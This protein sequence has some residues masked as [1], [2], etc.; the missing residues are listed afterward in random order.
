M[1]T[2][3]NNWIKREAQKRASQYLAEKQYERQQ[4]AEARRDFVIIAIGAL[5][6]ASIAG[7]FLG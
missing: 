7:N 4:T 1:S 5:L 3:K 2:I 6:V